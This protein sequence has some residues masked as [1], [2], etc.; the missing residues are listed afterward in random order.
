[1]PS[2]LTCGSHNTSAC[3]S[4]KRF[5]CSAAARSPSRWRISK[6]SMRFSSRASRT[7]GANTARSS[8]HAGHQ[9]SGH[10]VLQ[11]LRKY[12]LFHGGVETAR[13]RRRPCSGRTIFRPFRPRCVAGAA[14]SKLWNIPQRQ[15][16]PCRA[17]LLFQV[18]H[19]P[20]WVHADILRNLLFRL[21]TDR[22]IIS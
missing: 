9:M 6:I 3:S 7:P 17:G 10:F 4:T 20:P 8:P 15:G 14:N 21:R 19:A 18:L 13:G 2:E 12:F 1:M 11:Q 5:R 16:C 22:T